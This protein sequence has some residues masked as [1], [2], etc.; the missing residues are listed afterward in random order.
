[1]THLRSHITDTPPS[2]TTTLLWSVTCELWATHFILVITFLLRPDMFTLV[3]CWCTSPAIF[4][5]QHLSNM[6]GHSRLLL[7]HYTDPLL[8]PV[9]SLLRSLLSHA[10]CVRLNNAHFEL[11]SPFHNS[12]T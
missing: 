11:V 6:T 10:A 4:V 5:T 12:L 8:P 3:Y 9:T 7:V 1:M 2:V